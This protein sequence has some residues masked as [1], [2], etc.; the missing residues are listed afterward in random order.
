M[1]LNH[2]SPL[3]YRQLLDGGLRGFSID[4][5]TERLPS[6]VRKERTFWMR[7]SSARP[8]EKLFKEIPH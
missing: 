8:R 6:E 1:M 5:S 2:F 4:C 3:E 7:Y